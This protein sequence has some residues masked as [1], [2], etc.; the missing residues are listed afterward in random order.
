MT[1]VASAYNFAS[2]NMA[3]LMTGFGISSIVFLIFTAQVWIYFWRHGIRSRENR[4]SKTLV[5]MLMQAA[6][7]AITT[8]ISSVHM[9]EFEDIP[10]FIGHMSTI[11]ALHRTGCKWRFTSTG[12]DLIKLT[13][14]PQSLTTSLVHGIFICRIFRL[15]KCLY[16]RRRM[17]FVLVAF[18]VMEQVFGLISAIYIFKLRSNP[19]YGAMVIWSTAISLGCSVINDVLIAGTLAY[20]LHKHRTTSPRTNQ[21]ITKL[22]IFCSQTGLITTQC[23]ICAL[24][25]ALTKMQWAVCRFDIGHLYMLYATCLLANFIAR[26][27]YLQPQTTHQTGISEISFTSFAQVI[28]VGLSDN[29][30]GHQETL[31]MQGKTDSSKDSSK[32]SSC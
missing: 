26:E 1:Q 19:N 25:M 18:C 7:L 29:H 11:G 20:I 13:V 17:T 3:S 31:V 2:G 23:S 32:A 9:M 28:H 16:G 30:S 15:E 6:Q 22:I 12:L 24:T 14:V 27:S 5:R 4:Q 21:M 10:C 8:H